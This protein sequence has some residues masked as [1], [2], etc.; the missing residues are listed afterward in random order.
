MVDNFQ[1]LNTFFGDILSE[2]PCQSDTR[3]YIVGV[4]E[5]QKKPDWQL[6]HNS[7][8]LTFAQAREKQ[9]FITFQNLADYIFFIKTFAPAHFQDASEDY[10]RTIGQISYYNC[11]RL[12]NKQW[13]C[14]EE[15]ADQ[16]TLLENET[17]H[18]LTKRLK[19]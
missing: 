13:R 10:Y 9:D 1:K 4:F 12:I 16:F 2:L 6:A 7:I 17:R 19:L 18:L 8:T 3:A 14:F 5:R 11:Y 15:L